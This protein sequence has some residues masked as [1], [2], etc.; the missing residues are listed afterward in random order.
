M[1]LVIGTVVD[2]TSLPVSGALIAVE[3]GTIPYP[4]MAV[5]SDEKGNFSI[6]LPSGNFRL[7]AHALVGGYGVVE[8]N[9]DSGEQLLIRLSEH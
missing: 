1:P 3:S 5:Y 7:S 9:S 2:D 4:D 6:Y 8:Y